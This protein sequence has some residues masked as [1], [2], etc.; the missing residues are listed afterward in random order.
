MFRYTGCPKIAYPLFHDNISPNGIGLRNRDIINIKTSICSFIIS[1]EE[2]K[3]WSKQTQ[4]SK[5]E[6]QKIF[7]NTS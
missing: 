1:G 5:F 2:Q 4:K 7:K 3:L 6:K